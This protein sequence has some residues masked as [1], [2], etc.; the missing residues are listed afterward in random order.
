[1]K[2]VCVKNQTEKQGL[3]NNGKYMVKSASFSKLMVKPD[4]NNRVEAILP[5]NCSRITLTTLVVEVKPYRNR[6]ANSLCHLIPNITRICV[7]YFYSK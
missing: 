7:I 6:C 1:M 2:I 4:F 5:N 3:A